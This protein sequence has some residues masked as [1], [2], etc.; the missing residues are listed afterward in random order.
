[1]PSFTNRLQHAWN[2]FMGRDPTPNVNFGYSSSVRL[3]RPRLSPRNE[4]SV[5]TAVYTRLSVDVS[6]IAIQH[7]KIDENGRYLETIKS[8]LNNV[9]TCEANIDQTGRAFIQDIVLSMFDE[10][11][12]AVVPTDTKINPKNTTSFDIEKMRTGKIVQWFPEHVQVSVYNEHTGRKEDIILP[13]KMVAIIENPFYSIMNEPNSTLQR[14]IRTLN[15]LDLINK[16]N[17]SG[18]LDLIVQLP[19]VIKSQS[20]KEQ[21]EARRKEIEAQLVGSKYGIAYTDGTEKFTQLNRP[22]ENTLWSQAKELTSML[23]NQ[24]GLSEEILNGTADE[25]K[26]NNYYNHTIEPILEVIVD[27]FERKFLSKTARTQGQA[28]RYF[29]DPFKLVPVSSLSDIADK[30]TRNEI[31]SPNEIRA[32]IGWKPSKDAAADELRNRNINQGNSGLA[33]MIPQEGIDPAYAENSYSEEE[34]P[35]EDE[36]GQFYDPG[37]TPISAL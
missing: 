33:G 29:R 8:C 18:K 27:E 12:V 32:I 14:L 20:R 5:V 21:A 35:A 3:D 13:K 6:A 17:A 34:N 28:I 15:D 2:A 25:S 9:L 19:Y 22:V 10:G 36:E 30:L 37:S 24:L 4:R 1:M 11:C 23:Y 16:Q 31:A 26:M 7:I